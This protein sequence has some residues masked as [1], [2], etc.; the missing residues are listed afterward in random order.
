MV[1]TPTLGVGDRISGRFQVDE[2]LGGYAL[3]HV[4][5]GDG[6]GQEV[7]LVQLSADECSVMQGMDSSTVRVTPPKRRSNA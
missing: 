1:N 4:A 3:G 7:V 5:L 2:L 6:A